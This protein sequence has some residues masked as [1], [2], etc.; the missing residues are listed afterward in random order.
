MLAAGA[1]LAVLL[2]ACGGGGGGQAKQTTST[3]AATTVPPTF[4]LTGL[5]DAERKGVNRPLLAV[6]IDGSE[7]G[8]PQTGL[9]KADVVVEEEVEGGITR[10]IAMFHS[11]DPGDVGPVR[12]IRPMDPNILAPMKGMFG[13]AGGI[14]DFQQKLDATQVQDVA[15]NQSSVQDAYHRTK[16]RQ[17]PLNLYADTNRLWAAARDTSPPPALW[18]FL[19]AGEASSGQPVTGVDIVFSPQARCAYTWDASSNTW[20]RSM[21]GTPHTVA[22]G[23]QI[24]PANVVIQKVATENTGF[25]D[26]AG[27]PVIESKVIGTGEAWFFV[28]GKMLH[29]QWSKADQGSLTRFTDDAGNPV[30]LKPGRSWL[31]I[32]TDR[33]TVTPQ[34]APASTGAPTSAPARSVPTTAKKK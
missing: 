21:N 10:F 22:S 3:A 14:P 7:K 16:D 30:K 5:P 13:F 34:V 20:R 18:A 26:P 23:D 27:S 29:G 19:G 8:R 25:V 9:D 2:S 33:G 24:A 31:E 1:A 11:T 12:S 17:A 32:V 4:P 28:D 15:Y 6:K